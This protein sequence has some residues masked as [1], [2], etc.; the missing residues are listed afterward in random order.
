MLR[1]LALL[2]AGA[3]SLPVIAA[4]TVGSTAPDFTLPDSTGKTHS[5]SE[6]KGKTVV[7]EWNNPE[8]PFVKKHYSSGNIPKQQAAAISDGVA[9][10]VI[11]S[12]ADGKQGHVDGG[13]ANSFLAQYDAKPTAY[14]FD[15]DGKVGHAYGAKTTPHLF[16]I[17]GSGVLRYAGGIDSI[18]STDKDDLAKATQ[19]VPQVLGEL[20]AGKPVS[21]A[22]S[23]PFGCGV[24]YG[25]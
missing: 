23:Q 11:N 5:L 14:L 12:G 17:D 21:V 2:V 25:S 7:L 9:W 6:F 13:A 18:P 10:L 8:C 3:L 16:V 4:T 24:K 20:K 15:T 19:Y 1:V 22:T